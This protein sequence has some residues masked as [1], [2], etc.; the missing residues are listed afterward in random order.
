[1]FFALKS[2]VDLLLGVGP[3]LGGRGATG[4]RHARGVGLEGFLWLR[5]LLR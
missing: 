3:L 5:L 4:D 1:M 2:A